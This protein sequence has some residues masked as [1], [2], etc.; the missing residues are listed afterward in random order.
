MTI[1]K[2]RGGDLDL[3]EYEFNAFCPGENLHTAGI[4]PAHQP[5]PTGDTITARAPP[6]LRT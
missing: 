4:T 1:M 3:V 5:Y 6:P 2:I